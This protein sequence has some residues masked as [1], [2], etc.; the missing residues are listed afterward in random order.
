MGEDYSWLLGDNQGK[1]GDSG[2]DMGPVPLA[3]IESKVMLR[4]GPEGWNWIDHGEEHIPAAAR[5]VPYVPEPIRLDVPKD[6]V[7]V[8]PMRAVGATARS[9]TSNIPRE[10]KPKSLSHREVNESKSGK[11]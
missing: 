6:P 10:R 2:N 5:Q 11:R 7:A 1:S 9:V 3:N 4:L 8:R